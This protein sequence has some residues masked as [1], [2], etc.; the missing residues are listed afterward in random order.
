M[1]ID[2][3][4]AHLH[5]FLAFVYPAVAVFVRRCSLSRRSPVICSFPWSYKPCEQGLAAVV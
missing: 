5:R 2:I 3:V 1:T 4:W